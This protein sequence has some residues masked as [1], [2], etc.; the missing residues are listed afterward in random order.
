MAKKKKLSATKLVKAQAREIV[1][2]P[3]PSRPIPD[4]STIAARKKTKHKKRASQQ[5]IDE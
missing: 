5:I 1:G 4:R 3:P 2:T